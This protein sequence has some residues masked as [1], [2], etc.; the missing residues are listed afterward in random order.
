MEP[1]G[2]MRRVLGVQQPA[3]TGEIPRI[4]LGPIE[5]EADA[6]LGFEDF[7]R[8][9]RPALVRA[10]SLTVGDIDLASEAIDEGM[11]RAYQ[12]WLL[13]QG[14]DSPSGWVYRV[15]LNWA[16]SV[17]RRR[18]FGGGR[19]FDAGTVDQPATAEPAIRRA[20]EALDPKHRAVVVCRYLLGWSEAET[21]TALGLR[22]GTVKSRLHRASKTLRTELDHLAKDDR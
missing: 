3:I 10:L 22:P 16:L 5:L 13:V 18:R 8:S 9:S 21:A 19:L 7:Y 11:T 1:N 17:L 15:S 20:L 14:L 6:A 4:H 2:S 12:R